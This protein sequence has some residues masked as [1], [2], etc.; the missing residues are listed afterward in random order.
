MTR[1]RSP[2]PRGPWGAS[3]AQATPLTTPARAGEQGYTL[4]EV[5]VAV[6][7]ASILMALGVGSFQRW[8]DASAHEGAA[9]SLQT[10]LRQTQVRAVTEGVS[11]CVTFDTTPGAASY[12]VHRFACDTSPLVKLLGPYKLDSQQSLSGVAFKAS[13]GTNHQAVT[14]RPSGTAWPGQL[15]LARAGSPKTYTIKVEGLTGR[16]SQS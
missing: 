15:T 6:A 10:V 8:A 9:T 1:R 7:L 14:F 12:T 16:V 13:N 11:L 3:S 2:A 4:V 5:L